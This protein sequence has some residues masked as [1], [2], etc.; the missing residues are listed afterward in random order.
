MIS[1]DAHIWC[2]LSLY[3]LTTILYSRI[4]R[5]KTRH[6]RDN[7]VNFGTVSTQRSGTL[8]NQKYVPVASCAETQEVL[9]ANARKI[10]R[11]ELDLAEECGKGQFGTV[12]RAVYNSPTGE[13]REVAVKVAK[14]S[15]NPDIEWEFKS[16]ASIMVCVFTYNHI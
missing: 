10:R 4:K 6:R 1:R 3:V 14:D 16:E 12:H 15:S 2:C 9:I 5:Q 8:S 13:R 7:H 11:S